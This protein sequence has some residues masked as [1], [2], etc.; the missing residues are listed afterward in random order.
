MYPL[1]LRDGLSVP[2]WACIALFLSLCNIV[3]EIEK[4]YQISDSGGSINNNSGTVTQ[5]KTKRKIESSN[6]N[7]SN[8]NNN[9]RP[10]NIYTNSATVNTIINTLINLSRKW[11]VAFLVLSYT[12]E[13]C[14]SS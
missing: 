13:R 8:N 9:N 7:N 11:K 12:G 1:L 3:Q 6:N 4:D 5:S 10:N 2:Y 14:F